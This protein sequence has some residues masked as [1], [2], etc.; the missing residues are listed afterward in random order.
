MKNQKI[1][2]PYFLTKFPEDAQKLFYTDPKQFRVLYCQKLTKVVKQDLLQ[3]AEFVTPVYEVV[4]C[5]DWYDS[6]HRKYYWY[7]LKKDNRRQTIDMF[8]AYS[9]EDTSDMKKSLQVEA[10]DMDFF[11]L[12][13]CVYYYINYE[14]KAKW[15]MDGIKTMNPYDREARP[16]ILVDDYVKE[17]Y[18]CKRKTSKYKMLK[19]KKEIGKTLQQG[20]Q[21]ITDKLINTEIARIA[22][23]N[24]QIEAAKATLAKYGTEL[25]KGY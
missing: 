5:S 14:N 17:I 10:G 23:V 9:N 18:S 3:M 13:R 8:D 4:F 1:K 7:N 11:N 19:T 2:V 20:C 24:K 22:N 16:E 25:V 21:E 12:L 15:D 6:W